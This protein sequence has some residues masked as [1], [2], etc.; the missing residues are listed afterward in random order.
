MT[1]VR[2]DPRNF[3]IPA[4]RAAYERGENITRMLNR[5]GCNDVEAIEITYDL[6]AGSYTQGVLDDPEGFLRRCEAMAEL[7][8]DHIRP[9]DVL[10]DCGTG[11][12]TTLSGLSQYLPLGVRLL[13]FD[14]SLSRLN[15]GSR[16]AERFMS[17]P[18]RVG[19]FAAYMECIP[20]MADSVDVV[21]TSHALE[22]NH[23]RETQLLTELLRVCRRKLVLFEPSYEDNSEQGKARMRQLGYIRD[24]TSHILAAGGHLVARVALPDPVNPLNPTYCHVI[25]K[26]PIQ[27]GASLDVPR[28]VCPRSNQVLER[29]EGYLWS[30]QGGF[31]YPIINGIALLRERDA[32]LMC[33]D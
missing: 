23:G 15:A 12:M 27:H 19:L 24:L 5:D 17:V 6:Q 26:V 25:E 30:R 29:R 9:L 10:L 1:D 20:L 2:Q 8:T 31:A 33:H 7:L 3:D 4:L 13:A 14:A 28:F 16:F 32:I 18:T 11:E 22:P 21:F